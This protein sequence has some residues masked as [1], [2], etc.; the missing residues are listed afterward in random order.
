LS[1]SSLRRWQ[2]SILQSLDQ[3]LGLLPL[4]K[5]KRI[6]NEESLESL[7]KHKL[8]IIFP[9]KVTCVWTWGVVETA[10]GA[11]AGVVASIAAGAILSRVSEELTLI[12]IERNSWNETGKGNS[13][14]LFSHWHLKSYIEPTLGSTRT[15]PVILVYSSPRIDAGSRQMQILGPGSISVLLPSSNSRS[16]KDSAS[17]GVDQVPLERESSSRAPRWCFV[18]RGINLQLSAECLVSRIILIMTWISR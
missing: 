17:A 1:R 10:V 5:L 11:A 3:Y 16:D 18:T 8:A 6:I 14:N 13:R 9:P 7:V 4:L 2:D 15:R 12:L